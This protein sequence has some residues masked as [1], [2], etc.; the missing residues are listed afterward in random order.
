MV[1][2][3]VYALTKCGARVE[4][5]VCEEEPRPAPETPSYTE[6]WLWEE[7]SPRIR[8]LPLS[9]GDGE[10]DKR[11]R[12]RGPYKKRRLGS[13]VLS[14]RS[15]ATSHLPLVEKQL[16]CCGLTLPLVWSGG[17]VQ[18]EEE[19]ERGRRVL[20]R[21]VD[22]WA[23]ILFPPVFVLFGVGYWVVLVGHANYGD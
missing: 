18:E 4:E 15:V 10:E 7:I 9:S 1:Y 16:P 19:E 20:W 2:L 21:E 13:V 23:K 6:Y 3:Q 12:S 5:D 22:N 17:G 11:P 8:D 14:G